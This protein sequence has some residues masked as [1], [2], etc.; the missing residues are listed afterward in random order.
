MTA[1]TMPRPGQ[2]KWTEGDS[3]NYSFPCTNKAENGSY[4]AHHRTIVYE[5]PE[6]RK[7]RSAQTK[8]VPFSRRMA[9]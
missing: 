5:T 6:Q 3:G 2:C 1:M 9:A 4:C 8:F 7:S